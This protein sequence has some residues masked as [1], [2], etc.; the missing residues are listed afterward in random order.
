[1]CQILWLFFWPW[2]F[3]H[4]QFNFHPIKSLTGYKWG[5]TLYSEASLPPFGSIRVRVK[6]ANVTAFVSPR[7]ILHGDCCGAEGG[8]C[9]DDFLLIRF[10]HLLPKSLAVRC[11]VLYGLIFEH[12]LPCDLERTCGRTAVTITLIIYY[13]FQNILSLLHFGFEAVYNW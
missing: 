8:F 3:F 13:H 12:P 11:Q 5:F 1:M 7:H 4:C 9:E 6:G 10:I 2:E